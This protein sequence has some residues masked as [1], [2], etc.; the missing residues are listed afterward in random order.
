MRSRSV[1]PPIQTSRAGND[2][3]PRGILASGSPYARK[4]SLD[5]AKLAKLGGTPRLATYSD[6]R[7]VY[8]LD[9]NL[10]SSQPGSAIRNQF[11][12]QAQ[13][14]SGDHFFEK[15]GVGERD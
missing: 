3:G 11:L 9:P 10:A 12:A 15:L 8:K 1:L 4:G 2:G 14:A 7:S 6:S 13:T 5:Y